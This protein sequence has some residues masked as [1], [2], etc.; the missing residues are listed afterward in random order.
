MS[1]QSKQTSIGQWLV[2]A[3]VVV[4]AIAA[5]VFIYRKAVQPAAPPAPVASP[6]KVS[7]APP[8]Q[9][10]IAHPISQAGP[11]TVSS[12]PL[13]ALDASDGEV[14]AALSGLAGDSGLRSLMLSD[15]IIRRIV[16]TVDALPRRDLGSQ[17]LPMRT[18]R[19]AF[20]TEKANGTTVISKRNA[21]RYAPY[22]R[23]VDNADPQALVAWYVRT[24]P[25]FQ[26][27]Y[28]DLGY[29]KGYFNDRL[30]Q[31]IDN[32]LAA[33]D[34]SG[35]VALVQPK[36]FYLYADPDL[37]SRSAGQ[38]LLMRVGP[39]NEAR[40]KAKLRAIR[41]ALTGAQLPPA[42]ASSAASG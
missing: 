32:M 23:I 34:P 29:P 27:A 24:Y 7:T 11:A 37:Q 4:A 1:K 13:P 31:A 10:A 21:E 22:M 36:V 28:R 9:P 40:I 33:P 2:A 12:T 19:G 15:Q 26:Q 41:A 6:A 42:T 14:S 20:V 18:P 39:A 38:K 35:P 8:P 17:L 3:V 30:I 5:G 25:L 16:A